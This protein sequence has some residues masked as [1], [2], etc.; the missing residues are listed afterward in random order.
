VQPELAPLMARLDGSAAVIARGSP[1]PA[2]DVHCPVGSLPLA[3]GTELTTIPA[4]VPY[5]SADPARVA[6]WRNRLPAGD[7][8]HVGIVWCG[9][10]GFT[11]DRTRSMTFAGFAPIVADP[12]VTFVTLN[13]GAAA[14]APALAPHPGIVDLA[15]AFS[16]FSDTAAVIASLDLV[17]TTDT[18]TAHL[19]GALGRPTWLLL[20]HSPDWRWLLDREDCPWYPSMRLFRQPTA[21]DWHSPVARVRQELGRFVA[22]RCRG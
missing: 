16:D 12:D 13:P 19:A 22:A 21:G 15:A 6:H 18:A 14:D 1:R 7:R 10:P 5:L 8:P 20:S 3:L 9:N 2:F 4:A 17:I 11:G